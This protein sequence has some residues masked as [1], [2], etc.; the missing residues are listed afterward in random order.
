MSTVISTCHVWHLTVAEELNNLN[1]HIGPPHLDLNVP[2][3]IRV[4]FSVGWFYHTENKFTALE[5]RQFGM[6]IIKLA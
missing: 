5:M 6:L 1:T 2:S 3:L 4:L